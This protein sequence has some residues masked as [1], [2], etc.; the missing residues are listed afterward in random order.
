MNNYYIYAHFTK[1]TNE[2]FYIGS[3]GV[4]TRMYSTKG[5]SRNVKWHEINEK[6]GY[7]AFVILDGL[8]A[9]E[10][11][12]E[13]CRLQVLNQPRACLYYGKGKGHK[14]S[15]ETK[16]KIG[17]ANRGRVHSEETRA[18]VSEAN[19]GNK[20]SLGNKHSE[21]SKAKM[22]EA[23]KGS[24]NPRAKKVVNCIGEIFNT[25]L[26]AAQAYNLKSNAGVVNA[27]KGNCKSAGK[28]SDGSKIKWQYC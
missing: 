7:E 27:C 21:E 1:D 24:N 11:L 6:H 20:K 14:K 9:P 2:C 19:K 16:L 10:A 22:S 28:Y 17:N 15:E 26:E 3:S 12:A 23:T 13:E 4:P 5:I 18:K 8:T 25:C